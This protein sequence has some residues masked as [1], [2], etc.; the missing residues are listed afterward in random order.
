MLNI[1]KN[2]IRKKKLY[3]T[4]KSTKKNLN[5]LNL[6]LVNNIITGFSK[7]SRQKQTFLI[8]F[9]NYCHSFD[10]SISSISV[11]SKKISLLQNKS[12]EP[13]LLG[14]NFI[15]N[16]NIKKSNFET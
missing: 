5:Q 1:L 4:V 2:T 3:F 11:N 6:L 9:I 8:A 15:I 14:S 10:S 7:Y 13:N 16:V 12:L